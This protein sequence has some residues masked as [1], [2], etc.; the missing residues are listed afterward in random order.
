VEWARAFLGTLESLAVYVKENFVT[1]LIWNAKGDQ[2][3]AFVGKTLTTKPTPT[4]DTTTEIS[5]PTTEKPSKKPAK[6]ALESNRWLIEHHENNH[7]IMITDTAIN[8]AVYI[9]DCKNSTVQIK[10]KV[11]AVTVDS[12]VKLG[13]AVDSTVATVDVVNSQSFALQVFK[14]VPTIAVDKCDGGE[15]YLSN[16]CL[17]VELLT[18]KTTSLNVLLPE[19]DGDFKEV[20]VPEQVKT[21]IEKG[22]LVNATVEHAG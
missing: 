9:Y 20:P 4:E 17:G 18:A 22:R 13:V 11:N 2:L 19:E 10:G 21:T 15:I 14:S 1:G 3:D 8:Q 6:T 16:E 7:E 5:T 12:C